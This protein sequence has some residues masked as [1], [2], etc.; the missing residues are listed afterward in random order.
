MLGLADG[1]GNIVCNATKVSELDVATS[2]ELKEAI[3][4]IHERRGIDDAS[5]QEVREKTLGFT[6]MGYKPHGRLRA[7]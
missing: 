1:G 7:R 6:Y 5:I 3:R 2:A 4:R